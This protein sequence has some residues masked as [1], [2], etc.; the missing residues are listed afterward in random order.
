MVILAAQDVGLRHNHVQIHELGDN[1]RARGQLR[2]RR[3]GKV[4]GELGESKG[5]LVH[6]WERGRKEDLVVSLIGLV[7]V[8]LCNRP[9]RFDFSLL[10]L[11]RDVRF[12]YT[13]R[14]EC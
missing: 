12:N 9:E 7:Y 14:G 3:E 13:C 8:K 6:G 10:R 11:M 4:R 1:A 5:E 2:E